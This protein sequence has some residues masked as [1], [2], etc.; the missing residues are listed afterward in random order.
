MSAAARVVRLV[1]LSL[2][3]LPIVSTAQDRQLSLRGASSSSGGGGLPDGS[4]CRLDSSFKPAGEPCAASPF[5]CVVTRVPTA[6][7]PFYRGVCNSSYAGS[8]HCTFFSQPY[9]VGTTGVSSNPACHRCDCNDHPENAEA[10][11]RVA[12]FAADTLS[13]HVGDTGILS[14][15]AQSS[16]R[17]I[18]ASLGANTA[19]CDCQV[20][21][22]C[23]VDW[24]GK[25]VRGPDGVM[26]PERQS[27]CVI[28]E[29]GGG[30]ADKQG[31]PIDAGTCESAGELN[32]CMVAGNG[33][34]PKYYA[35]GVQGLPDALDECKRCR[36]SDGNQVVGC[37]KVP[38][39]KSGGGGGWDDDAAA[40][41][42]AAGAAAVGDVYVEGPK[43]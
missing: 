29:V 42:D 21:G 27:R 11:A 13:K 6:K 8:P 10:T 4:A 30:G 18:L 9:A 35:R 39:C 22:P 41:A 19:R 17:S 38:K 5:V 33:W 3:L 24:K 31:R 20:I 14:M 32:T 16:L 36:C 23:Y 7:D 25:Q 15:S 34:G 37:V 2:C 28:Q 43:A 26:C 40:A 1:A 12:E